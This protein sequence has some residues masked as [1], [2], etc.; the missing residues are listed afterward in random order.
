M[1]EEEFEK[2]MEEAAKTQFIERSIEAAK[3]IMAQA[4]QDGV[5]MDMLGNWSKDRTESYSSAVI[6]RHNLIKDDDL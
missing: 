1:D 5:L 2:S 3:L 6:E 4:E